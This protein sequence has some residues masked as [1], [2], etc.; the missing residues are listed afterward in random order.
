MF[1]TLSTCISAK[2]S[3]ITK[4]SK[5]LSLYSTT[6]AFHPFFFLA[7]KGP[8]KVSGVTSVSHNSFHSPSDVITIVIIFK[9]DAVR[10]YPFLH[11][12]EEYLME[13]PYYLPSP[14]LPLPIHLDISLNKNRNISSATM[15]KHTVDERRIFAANQ[16]TIISI[17][18]YFN[19]SIFFFSEFHDTFYSF[20]SNEIS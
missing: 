11:V 13:Y 18:S 10:W 12:G 2:S 17:S 7:L 16:H 6:P 5:P 4:R 14:S 9:G 8:A 20:E 15:A 3:M 19:I 1:L